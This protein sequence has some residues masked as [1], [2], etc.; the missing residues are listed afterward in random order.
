MECLWPL[1]SNCE[2]PIK[3]WKTFF[4]KTSHESSRI[5]NSMIVTF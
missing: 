5:P 2:D 3:S 4:G 1:N